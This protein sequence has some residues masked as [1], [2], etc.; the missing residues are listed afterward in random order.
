[1]PAIGL[2]HTER[3][4]ARI[5]LLISARVVRCILVRFGKPFKQRERFGLCRRIDP[6]FRLNAGGIWSCRQ[7]GTSLPKSSPALFSLLAGE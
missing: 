3:R 6:E 5:S 7:I 1:M 2:S 4:F